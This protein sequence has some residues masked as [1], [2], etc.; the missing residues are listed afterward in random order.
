MSHA[1]LPVTALDADAA[2]ARRAL[3]VALA[4]VRDARVALLSLVA[5]C[6]EQRI[7]AVLAAIEAAMTSARLRAGQRSNPDVMRRFYLHRL[8]ARQAVARLRLGDR[9]A[10]RRALDRYIAA[11]ELRAER[12]IAWELASLVAAGASRPGAA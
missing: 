10:G 8:A 9:R 6:P 5:R 7:A 12:E 2:D 3:D 4:D 1:G 11:E